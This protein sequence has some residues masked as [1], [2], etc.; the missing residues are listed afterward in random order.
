L[1][2]SFA[3]Q[4]GSSIITANFGFVANPTAIELISFSAHES[5]GGVLINWTTGWERD[6]LG[7]M[8]YRSATMDGQRD[9]VNPY[10]VG[11]RGTGAGAS[12]AWMDTGLE[13]GHYFYWLEDIDYDFSR[14]LHGP[15]VVPV[16]GNVLASYDSVEQSIVKID[17]DDPARVG[18]RVNGREVA[19]LAVEGGVI[20]FVGAA[21]E[22]VD[23]IMT[24]EPLRMAVQD[25]PPVAGETVM[26]QLDEDLSAHFATV[27]GRNYFVLGFE[28]QPVVLDIS[29]PDKPV[30]IVGEIVEGESG[31]SVYFAAPASV[32]VRTGDL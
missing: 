32:P 14:T 6:N 3:I 12:Y 31:R 17:T 13:A 20:F 24:D 28:G 29:D 30:Q 5:V 9:L 23:V 27:Q 4:S 22:A 10:M 18:I 7:F 19:S 25:A 11:G 26:I 2:F 8:I 21:G 1:Q 16:A 15:A